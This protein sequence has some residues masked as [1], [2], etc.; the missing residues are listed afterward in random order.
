MSGS[1]ASGEN[2][3]QQAGHGSFDPFTAKG[4]LAWCRRQKEAGDCR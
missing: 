1:L 3:K 2:G 4:K